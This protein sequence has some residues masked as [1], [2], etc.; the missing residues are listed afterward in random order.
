MPRHGGRTYCAYI[1]TIFQNPRVMP[2]SMLNNH[3]SFFSSLEV[4]LDVFP[5]E[6]T[7]TDPDY[8]FSA[9]REGGHLIMTYIWEAF[10]DR[11]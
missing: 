6:F 11:L 10:E 4:D 1:K 8:G 3:T 5:T 2:L 9:A 7:E